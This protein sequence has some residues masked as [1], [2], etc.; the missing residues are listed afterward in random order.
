MGI[1]A[2]VF[3][4][5][6]TILHSLPDL[7]IATNEALTRMGFPTHTEEEIVTFVGNGAE[8]LIDQSTPATAT[9][10]QRRETLELWRSIYINSS[11]DNTAPFPGIVELLRQLRER[12]VGTA[13]LSNKFDAGVQVLAERFFPGLFDVCRGEVPPIPRKPDPTA[14]FMV[15]EELGATPQ[16]TVYVGDTNVDVQVARAAGVM[17]VGVSWGYDKA[18]P[19]PVDELDAYIHDPA[20]ILSLPGMPAG[21]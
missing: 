14:L 20:E 11:Y 12:G 8:R 16:E 21:A 5:D 3:D 9:P 4:M 2:I 10:Q 13:V 6:G 19:L 17:A 15:M 18:L 7:V 1:K